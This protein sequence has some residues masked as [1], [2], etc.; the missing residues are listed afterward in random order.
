MIENLDPVLGIGGAPTRATILPTDSKA[1]KAFPIATGFLDYFPDAVAAV[2]NVSFQAAAQHGQIETGMH[3][4]RSKSGNECD[5]L[6]RH[7]VQRG[8]LDTDGLR[9]TAKVVWRALAMLQKEI[10][11]EKQRG[12]RQS[13]IRD[14][15]DQG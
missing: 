11:A 15:R 4:D 13:S 10:E 9:H 12:E 7:F 1:R 6:M 2:A 14:H 8:T 3:W 5:T